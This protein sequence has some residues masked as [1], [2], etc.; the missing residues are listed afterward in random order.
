MKSPASFGSRCRENAIS[1]VAIFGDSISVGGRLHPRRTGAGQRCSPQRRAHALSIAPCP[2]RYC[3][4]HPMPAE[5]HDPDNGLSRAHRD[6]IAE[7]ADAICVL[8]GYNDA[9]LHGSARIL[10]LCRVRTR[11]QAAY[12]S[13]AR[14]RLC[15]GDHRARE[16]ALPLRQRIRRRQRRLHLRNGATAFSPMSMWCA[17]S[18]LRSWPLLCAGLRNHGGLPGWQSFVPGR[19][20]SQ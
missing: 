14:R 10:Q 13:A 2:E 19:H 5:R 15:A 7:P 16:S 3:R 6:L 17:M 1:S 12:R 8:Y 18:R 20:P 9:R 4:T 11:L